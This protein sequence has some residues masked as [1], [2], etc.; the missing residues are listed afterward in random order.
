MLDQQ[1]AAGVMVTASHNP[2]ADNG[3]KVYLGDGPRSSR[4]ATSAS[5]PRC[6]RRRRRRRARRARRR[7]DHHAAV[8]RRRALSRHDAG[9]ATAPGPGVAVAYTAM[10]GV[11]GDTMVAAFRRVGFAAPIVV[12]EQF[13]PDPDFPTVAFPNPE[14]PGAMD[15]VMAGCGQR[16]CAGARQRRCR[17]SRRRSRSQMARGGDSAAT[18]SAGCSPTTSCATQPAATGW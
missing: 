17:P 9:G 13:T 1:A 14:E 18:R 10:H 15:L 11:G 6:A 5:P 4:R 8:G 12:A 7:V 2:P 16:L 3:Y